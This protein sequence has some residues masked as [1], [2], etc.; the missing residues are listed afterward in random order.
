MVVRLWPGTW[1]FSYSDYR[2]PSVVTGTSAY[3]LGEKVQGRDGTCCQPPSPHPGPARP[4]PLPTPR[5]PPPPL[6]HPGRLLPPPPP[7]SPPPPLPPP[8][9]LPPP[10]PRSPP[11]PPPLPSPPVPVWV[12]L[13][14]CTS[15]NSHSP[16]PYLDLS[17]LLDAVSRTDSIIYVLAREK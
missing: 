8:R 14:S 5:S 4:P 1:T 17:L 16:L 7:G 13:F 9:P 15:W 12:I 2:L 3:A 6:P 10:P 11:W